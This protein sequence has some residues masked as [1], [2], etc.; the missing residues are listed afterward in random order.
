[1]FDRAGRLVALHGPRTAGGLKYMRGQLRL[2]VLQLA[3]RLHLPPGEL[4]AIEI[5]AAPTNDLVWA[6]VASLFLE[7]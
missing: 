2:G 4:E 6:A 3:E 7:E 5:G 1:M